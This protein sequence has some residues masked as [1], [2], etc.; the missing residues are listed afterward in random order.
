MPFHQRR[1]PHWRPDGEIL[2]ITW[3]LHGSLPPHRY[4]PPQGLT[5]GQAFVWMDRVLDEARCGPTWLRQEDIA[6]LVVDSIHYGAQALEHYQLHA[7]VVMA[8]HVHV[9]LLPQVDPSKLMQSLKGF[10]AREA[11]KILRRTGEPFWQRE[12]YDHWV[13]DEQEFGR[14]RAYIENNPVRAGLVARAEDYPWS[15]AAG[16]LNT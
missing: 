7:Y 2:F 6:R 5:S 14:I 1:L 15:S 10:T 3:R 4:V 12:S 8:N 9:L 13:R 11:N 16:R